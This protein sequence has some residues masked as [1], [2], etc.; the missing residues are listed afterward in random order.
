MQIN[1]LVTPPQVPTL[2]AGQRPIAQ[3]PYQD[4]SNVGDEETDPFRLGE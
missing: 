1:N 4:R 2:P 3:L